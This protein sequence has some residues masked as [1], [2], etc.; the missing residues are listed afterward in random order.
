MLLA[1]RGEVGGSLPACSFPLALRTEE[2]IPI[3]AVTPA[4]D[5]HAM[6]ILDDGVV[7]SVNH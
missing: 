6:A 7:I 3:P 1:R 4:L 2:R 5:P